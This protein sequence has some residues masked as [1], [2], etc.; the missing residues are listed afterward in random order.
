MTETLTR[1]Y[2]LRPG[3]VVLYG[4]SRTP[5]TVAAVDVAGPLTIIDFTDGTSSPPVP[6]DGGA[7]VVTS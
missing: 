5:L 2:D 4:P 3:D 6:A 1:I 7:T